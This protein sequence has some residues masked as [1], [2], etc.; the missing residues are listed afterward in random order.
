MSDTQDTGTST[1]DA[2]GTQ[3]ADANTQ[4]AGQGQVEQQAA[5]ASADGT[6]KA[7]ESKTV[8]EL[9]LEVPEGVTL[10]QASLDEFK[11]IVS[12]KALTEAERAQKVLDIAIKREQ[13]RA[14][15]FRQQVE[16][17]AAE[18]K[19]DKELGAPENL[20][21]A[22]KAV[23]TFG[24]PELKS[25]LNSTGMG[26]HPEVVRFMLQVGKAIS[27]DKVITGKAPEGKPRDPASVLYPNQ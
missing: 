3:N 17:W 25:L 18:V 2:G 1:T 13:S 19:A 5:D 21:V 11:A 22:V 14:D 10:D 9:K 12:D 8:E 20:A 15:A 7:G 24:S 16:D 4:A 26:N 27:E 6:G 23:D